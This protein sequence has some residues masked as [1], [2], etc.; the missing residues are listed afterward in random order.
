MI[1]GP[2][3]ASRAMAPCQP[4][5]GH[6]MPRGSHAHCTGFLCCSEVLDG[7]WGSSP[8]NAAKVIGFCPGDTGRADAGPIN[9]LHQ[10]LLRGVSMD[11]AV[12]R[13]AGGAAT[14][15][16]GLLGHGVLRIHHIL[17]AVLCQESKQPA[18]GPDTR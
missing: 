13:A 14:A 2:V 15:D 3:P 11:L 7:P 6:G 10:A 8:P 12:S 1:T 4:L 5:S 9:S 18:Q 16:A 17:R